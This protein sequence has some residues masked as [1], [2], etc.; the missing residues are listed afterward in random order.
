VG[1]VAKLTAN[2]R[3]WRVFYW[4]VEIPSSPDWM[5]AGRDQCNWAPPT[6][7]TDLR[8][9]VVVWEPLNLDLRPER[10]MDV[11]TSSPS[12]RGDR[13]RQVVAMRPRLPGSGRQVA[14]G[15]S[16]SVA[17]DKAMEQEPEAIRLR[18]DADHIEVEP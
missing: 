15:N 10:N 16:S 17:V 18:A 9:S 8:L 4:G 14:T 13:I 5:R 12:C 2:L 7:R 11:F 6:R 3:A 1:C